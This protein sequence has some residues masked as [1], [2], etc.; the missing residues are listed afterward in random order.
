ML[1]GG[2][3]IFGS[4]NYHVLRTDDGVTMVPKLT[5]SFSDIYVDVRNF[6]VTDWAQHKALAAAIVKAKKESIFKDSTSASV[7]QGVDNFVNELHGLSG[8]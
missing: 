7:K 3:L 6:G 1:V 4:Q 8:Q 2:G 5:S